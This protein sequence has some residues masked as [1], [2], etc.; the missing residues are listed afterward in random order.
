MENTTPVSVD[1]VS[2]FLASN[3][4]SIRRSWNSFSVCLDEAP[5]IL[6]INVLSLRA[7]PYNLVLI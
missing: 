2:L 7:S 4:L 5:D 6:D 1:I 3:G